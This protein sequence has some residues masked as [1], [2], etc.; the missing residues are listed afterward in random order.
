MASHG[1]SD[2]GVEAS[3]RFGCA[4]EC[5]R[6]GCGSLSTTSKTAFDPVDYIEMRRQTFGAEFGMSLAQ[7]GLDA[8]P[9]GAVSD[10]DD[11]CA[12]QL[13]GGCGGLINDIVSIAKEIEIEGG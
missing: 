7:F 9:C 12:R 6:A 5:F 1:G 8:D 3:Q 11:S 10:A 4:G 13:G 2:E